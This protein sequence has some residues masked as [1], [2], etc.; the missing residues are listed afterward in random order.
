M[1]SS[2]DEDAPRLQEF[3]CAF[4]GR[5]VIDE[6]HVMSIDGESWPICSNCARLLKRMASG[7]E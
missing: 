5:I 3:K 6:K 1:G 4:C 7:G 2:S